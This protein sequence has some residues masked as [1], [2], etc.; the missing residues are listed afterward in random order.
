VAGIGVLGVPTNSAGRTDGVAR[1]PAALRDAGLLE[2][3]RRHGEVHDY[4]DVPLPSPSPDRDPLSHVIDPRGLEAMVAGVR[5]AVASI[6][7]DDR[8]PLAL[9][10]DCPLLLGCLAAGERGSIGLLFVDGHED[11]YPPERSR[12]GEAAD[13]ELGLALGSVDVPWSVE[14]GE[15]LP[16]VDPGDVR[17]LGARDAATLR[18][19]GVPSIADLVELVDG[20]ALAADPARETGAACDAL[21][22]A[23]WFHLDLDVLGAA[24]LPAVDYP[25]EG[26]L[27]WEEIEA[28]ALAALAAAP[29]GRDVT[30]FNPDLDP[31]GANA[32][33]IV[34][35]LGAAARSIV[36]TTRTAG[37]APDAR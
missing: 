4:G 27:G 31:D 34:R 23:W 14:L 6:L 36:T 22:A 28:V 33:R 18:A 29:I 21:G 30:I 8:F 35:F 25:Q 1:G 19:E 32:R 13:M 10:G 24:A 2:A 15:L 20:D 37:G 16:L 7:R 26:G 3:L 11:A 12:T 9:G 17:V 5:D